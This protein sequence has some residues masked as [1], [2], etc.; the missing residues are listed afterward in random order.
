[1]ID[2][3]LAFGFRQPSHRVEVI[4]LHAIKIVFRFGIDHAKHGVSVAL[5]MDVGNPPIVADNGG[6]LRFRLYSFVIG[7]GGERRR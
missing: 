6:V 2:R 1:M 4:G 3:L 7:A 5:P